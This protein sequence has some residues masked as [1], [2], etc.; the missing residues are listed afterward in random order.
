[1]V[2]DGAKRKKLLGG[3]IATLIF[4]LWIFVDIYIFP[5]FGLTSYSLYEILAYG[6]WT[7]IILICFAILFWAGFFPMRAESRE[8]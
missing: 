1:M 5:L 4:V 7:L 8:L 6:S 2:Q 3:I